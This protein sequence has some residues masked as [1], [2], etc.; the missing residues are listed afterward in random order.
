MSNIPLARSL[1]EA[2]IKEHRKAL[3][4]LTKALSNMTKESSP[5][6]K[7]VSD[8]ELL[9]T[10]FHGVTVPAEEDETSKVRKTSA[11]AK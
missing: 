8:R 10:I 6:S 3:R 4:K 11:E 7:R 5:K 2:A 9:E 1:I